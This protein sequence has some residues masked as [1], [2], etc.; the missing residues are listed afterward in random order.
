MKT[1]E[2]SFEDD[3]LE[4][5]V[6]LRSIV[7]LLCPLSFEVVLENLFFDFFV[8]VQLAHLCHQMNHV[9]Q[10]PLSLFLSCYHLYLTGHGC[11]LN[12][13]LCTHF[14]TINLKKNIVSYLNLP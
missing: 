7:S 12:L 9:Y 4:E 10:T 2:D 1:L 13:L 14:E 5:S 8:H 6:V 11:L 3:E